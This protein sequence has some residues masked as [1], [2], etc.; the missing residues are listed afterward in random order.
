[1]KATR[2]KYTLVLLYSLALLVFLNSCKKKET[3]EECP[4][5]PSVISISPTQA[6]GYDILT[7]T[8]T[9]F[10]SDLQS[11][12]VKI[13]GVQVNPDSILSG[14]ETQLIV[15]V[16]KRCGSGS[17]TVDLDAELTNFGS[18]PQFNYLFRYTAI[19]IGGTGLSVMPCASGSS[20]CPSSGFQRSMGIVLDQNENV[21]FS[22][23]GLHQIFQLEKNSSYDPC[24]VAGCGQGSTN[25][26]GTQASMDSPSFI[27]INSDGT[28]FVPE[29]GT[30]I[31]TVTSFGTVAPWYSN[32]DL[33]MAGGAIAF[34]QNNSEI[35]YVTNPSS[36]SIWKINHSGGIFSHTQFAGSLNDSGYA[37]GPDTTASFYSPTGIVVDNIGKC[38]CI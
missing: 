35:A 14:S 33:N 38:I 12:I 16:P 17:V 31:R 11:N 34:L 26:S 10:S 8:G 37:D 20:S 4:N 21:F 29:N 13:N 32:N 9:N 30:A 28:M 25:G 23:A 2:A 5:C 1:M 3:D 27:A 7:I 6:Y 18:P 36:H 19:D 15:K 22:D 24:L